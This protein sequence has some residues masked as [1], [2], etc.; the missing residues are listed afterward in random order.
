[1]SGEVRVMD[2]MQGCRESEAV[3]DDQ[4]MLEARRLWEMFVRRLGRQRLQM[5]LLLAGLI[6]TAWEAWMFLQRI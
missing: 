6:I 4:I 1:M 5:V 3:T 2:R